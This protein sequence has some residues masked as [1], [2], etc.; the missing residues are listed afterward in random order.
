[1]GNRASFVGAG[2]ARPGVDIMVVLASLC[3]DVG[4]NGKTIKEPHTKEA[5]TMDYTTFVG[6]DVHKDTIRSRQDTVGL[7]EPHIQLRS[8]FVCLVPLMPCG[9]SCFGH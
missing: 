5:S 7:K 3:N 9:S 1:V 4:Y 8:P 2:H 6:M